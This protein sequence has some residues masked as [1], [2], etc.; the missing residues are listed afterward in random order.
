M[1]KLRGVNVFPEAVGAI[2]AEDGSSNGEYVCILEG[3]RLR[4]R[5]YDRLVEV[6]DDSV[7]QAATWNRSSRSG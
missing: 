2:V 6:L 4:P 7:P 3:A 5:G 1:V